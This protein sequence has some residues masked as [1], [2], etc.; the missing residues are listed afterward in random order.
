MESPNLPAFSFATA[1]LT[2]WAAYNSI[3]LSLEACAAWAC[4]FGTA[5]ASGIQDGIGVPADRHLC[6][7]SSTRLRS[8]GRL[9]RP[10][11]RGY[12]LRDVGLTFGPRL[13]PP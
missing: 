6:Q 8:S 3:F 1:S 13:S 7:L 5:C 10:S 12:R 9:A 11:D 2:R 4:C